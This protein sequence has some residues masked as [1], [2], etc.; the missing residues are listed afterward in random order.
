M[1]SKITMRC[2]HILLGKLPEGHVQ[3]W[4]QGPSIAVKLGSKDDTW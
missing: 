2:M 3:A 4:A 1:I